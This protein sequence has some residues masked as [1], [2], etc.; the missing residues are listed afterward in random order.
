MHHSLHG[1]LELWLFDDKGIQLLFGLWWSLV[2][3][4]TE[5]LVGL[6]AMPPLGTLLLKGRAGIFYICVILLHH[7]HFAV[8]SSDE[9]MS[10]FMQGCSQSLWNFHANCWHDC[11]L[12]FIVLAQAC[13]CLV[14]L[15]KVSRQVGL[16][17]L[18]YLACMMHA[19]TMHKR[20]GLQ[21][22]TPCM[23]CSSHSYVMTKGCN[24]YLVYEGVLCW[25]WQRA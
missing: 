18:C 22:V 23:A 14:L 1:L 13:C 15:C 2:L 17:Q 12:S 8:F 25:V 7:F 3:G 21:C 6:F 16:L 9:T 5:G 10:S 11:P 24:C 19:M 20:Q 4:V